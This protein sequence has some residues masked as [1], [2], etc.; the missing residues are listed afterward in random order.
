M[1]LTDVAVPK[2]LEQGV[3]RVLQVILLGISVYGALQGRAAVVLNGVVPLLVTFLPAY[4]RR[5]YRVRMDPGIVF[6]LAVA[7][8]VHAIGMLGPY[9]SVQWYDE[10]AHALSAS[11]V[12]LSG[13]AT[14][15]ALDIHYESIELPPEF[16]R[17]A[18]V[19]FAIAF[20]GLWELFELLLGTAAAA[21]GFEPPLIVFGLDD[22]VL[23]I[24]FNTIGGIV[25]AVVAPGHLTKLPTT[26][27]TRLMNR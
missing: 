2:N 25:V 8:T 18:T 5:D 6:L 26:L 21:F 27:A 3:V 7:A 23:D 12:A 17:A 15:Q 19:I 14:V 22:A 10:V 13:Y 1:S 16:L 9:E 24:V 4:L 20:G 11:V